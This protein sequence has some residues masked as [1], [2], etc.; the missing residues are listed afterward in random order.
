MDDRPY[1]LI[2]IGVVVALCLLAIVWSIA[3]A[4][5]VE[6]LYIYLPLVSNGDPGP[7]LKPTSTPRPTPT[8]APT[9]SPCIRMTMYPEPQLTPTQGEVP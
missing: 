7:T 5:E 8:L 4:E 3:F 1:V 2:M 6:Q 9:M